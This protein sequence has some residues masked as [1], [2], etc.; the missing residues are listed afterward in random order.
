MTRRLLTLMTLAAV[1]VGVAG[2]GADK[3]EARTQGATEGLY[4]DVGGLKYQVQISRILNPATS[5]TAT[6]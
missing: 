5:R 3:Q 1:V 6:T 2:C 4:L